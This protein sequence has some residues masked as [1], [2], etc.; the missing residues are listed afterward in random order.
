MPG[1]FNEKQATLYPARRGPS[2]SR[3]IEEDRRASARRVATLR[4]SSKKPG[5]TFNCGLASISFRTNGPGTTLYALFKSTSLARV[6][7]QRVE[8]SSGIAGGIIE[9]HKPPHLYKVVISHPEMYID[10][11]NYLN[12]YNCG[13]L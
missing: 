6:S 2:S 9:I 12:K 5:L 3:L 7:L 8:T 1:P 11:N 13:V 10:E 4:K